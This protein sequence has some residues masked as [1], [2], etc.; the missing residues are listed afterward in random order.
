MYILIVLILV[1]WITGKSVYRPL[2][3]VACGLVLTVWL[4]LFAGVGKMLATPRCEFDLARPPTG[5]GGP[6]WT[7]E[8]MADERFVRLRDGDDKLV[9][10]AEAARLTFDAAGRA[11]RLDATLLFQTEALA[12][13][14]LEEL[15]GFFATPS[16]STVRR[17]WCA[18]TMLVRSTQAGPKSF[19]VRL[20]MQR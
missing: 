4:G 16:G 7:S 10:R 5:D 2:M 3:I 18:T 14:S 19:E 15:R 9:F 11:S 1:G 6:E 13:A 17:G 8:R 12:A 20:A